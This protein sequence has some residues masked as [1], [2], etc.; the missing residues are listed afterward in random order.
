MLNFLVLAVQC[1]QGIRFY[2]DELLADQRLPTTYICMGRGV[3]FAAFLWWNETKALAWIVSVSR[4]GRGLRLDLRCVA[5]GGKESLDCAAVG[6]VEV[7]TL[8]IW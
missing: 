8:C 7:E 2:S 1:G 4:W 5:L 6:V 3:C